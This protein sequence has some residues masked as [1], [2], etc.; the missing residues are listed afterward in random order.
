MS[1]SPARIPRKQGSENYFFEITAQNWYSDPCFE[2]AN[3]DW[4]GA[5]SIL[6]WQQHLL[7]E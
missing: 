6:F 5:A 3:S 4:F 2:K 1:R 7:D